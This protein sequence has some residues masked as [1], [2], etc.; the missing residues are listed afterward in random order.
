MTKMIRG[1]V[2]GVRYLDVRCDEC[3]AVMKPVD[4]GISDV[5][6]DGSWSNLQ[7]EGGLLV[8]LHGYFGGFA[9]QVRDMS[10]WQ[11]LLSSDCAGRLVA[12][13]GS[14]RRLVDED[15]RED[16]EVDGDASQGLDKTQRRWPPPAGEHLQPA[17]E[18]VP[19]DDIQHEAEC[20]QL[21]EKAIARLTDEDLAP[22]LAWH[23][24]QQDEF[25]GAGS[26]DRLRRSMAASLALE[27]PGWEERLDQ[28]RAATV[29][30]FLHDV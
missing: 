24:T 21:F 17:S 6:E 30:H 3:G 10:K 15:R 19:F 16:A 25:S 7:A 2:D 29:R 20:A 28:F 14:L 18:D 13:F 23:A 12:S 27:R 4:A 8:E 1:R 5:A 11:A 22:W 26:L 9:D